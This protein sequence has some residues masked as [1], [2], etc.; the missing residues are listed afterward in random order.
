MK[1][2]DAQ[3][4][5]ERLKGRHP[6]RAFT[7]IELMVVIAIVGILLGLILPGVSGM[8][9]QRN[10]AAAENMLQGLMLSARTRAIRAGGYGLFFFV[11]KDGSQRVVFL[12]ADPPDPVTGSIDD[13]DLKAVFSSSAWTDGMKLT[14]V[15]AVDRFRVVEGDIYTIPKPYRV[16][17]LWVI[18]A[19]ATN[20]GPLWPAS[21]AVDNW[22]AAA[23]KYTPRYHR[24]YFTV[25][26]NRNGEL[27]VNR[28]V[29]VHDRDED[30]LPNGDGL[31]D[32][33]GMPVASEVSNTYDMQSDPAIFATVRPINSRTAEQDPDLFD[34]VYL[35][36]PAE[37]APPNNAKAANFFSVDGLLVYDESDLAG[38]DAAGR[39]QVLVQNGQPYYVGRYTGDVILGP[40]GAGL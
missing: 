21:L 9:A 8:W 35:T 1:Q 7:L 32:L 17:P 18:D 28:P 13:T 22:Q 26:F 6:L 2:H 11:D 15:D 16:A 27:V 23:G 25:M 10:Q 37:G 34:I 29:L 40:K 20:T 4:L 5:D 19:N 3:H 24:N 39:W 30:P 12:E 38:L 31:G 33:T 36:N 14:A